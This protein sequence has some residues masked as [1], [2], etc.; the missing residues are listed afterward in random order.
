MKRWTR[1]E[2]VT[3]PDGSALALYEHDGEYTLRVGGRELMST[4]RHAS[5][6]RLGE[7]GGLA[8]AR[9]PRGRVLVGGLG[10]GFT[11]RGA[12]KTAPPDAEVVV[13]ELI[14]DVVRWN[15]V[16]AYPL[17]ARELA[18]PRTRVVVG[19]VFDVIAGAARSTDDAFDAILLDADNGT[20]AMMTAGNRELFVASGLRLVRA[21]L[22]DGGIA[23]Y[24]SAGP[25][26]TLERLMRK[27]G[28]SVRT[29]RV[30]AYG[31]GG[32]KYSLIVG[33]AP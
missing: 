5:E 24:W 27:S 10:L 25:E 32:P 16:P 28:F 13:A 1:L 19:D 22:R 3:T 31:S 26:P 4:R 18:D 23:V 6:L 33:R 14:E 11:L 17:A 2:Q 15:R 7:L 8:A 9:R 21:A 29:E 12:L 20:T 30:R